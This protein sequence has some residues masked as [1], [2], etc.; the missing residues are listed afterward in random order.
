MI[1]I[2]KVTFFSFFPSLKAIS[3]LGKHMLASKKIS[4]SETTTGRAKR[5]KNQLFIQHEHTINSAN[6]QLKGYYD[7][8][9]TSNWC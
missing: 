4:L 8:I 5:F 3:V 7:K 2:V 6:I 1:K 9:L